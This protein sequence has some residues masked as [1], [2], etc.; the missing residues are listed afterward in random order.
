MADRIWF[1]PIVPEGSENQIPVTFGGYPFW[2]DFATMAALFPG[3]QG[4]VGP[5]GPVGPTGLTG[6]TGPVGPPGAAGLD[7]ATGPAGPVGATGP[8]GP[9]GVPGVAGPQGI[10]GDPGLQGVAG[11]QGLPGPTGS[12]GVSGPA[13]P[14]GPIGPVGPGLKSFRGSAVTNGSGIATFNLAAAA[15]ATAPIVA[16]VPRLAAGGS[17]VECRVTA[18]TAASC[19]VTCRFSALQ[20]LLGLTLLSAPTAASGVTIHLVAFPAGVQT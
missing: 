19:T 17:L 7:G 3:P 9:Q 16:V 13:G 15:F 14:A 20:T 12:Q 5:I 10:Q 11:P 8:V 1:P 2:I 4:E 18:L 6:A